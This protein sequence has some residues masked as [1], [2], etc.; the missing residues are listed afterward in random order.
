MSADGQVENDMTDQSLPARQ[1]QLTGLFPKERIAVCLLFLANGFYTG[2][3]SLKIPELSERLNL[4]PFYIALIVVFFG[5]GSITIM[6]L[7]GARIAKYGTS[8]V[9]KAT[10][11]VFLFTMIG[12]SLAPNVW[13]AAIAVFLFGGFAGAMDVAMNANAVEVEKSMR[14]A[15]MSSCHAFWS[16]GALIGSSAG[17]FMI[18]HFGALPHSLIITVVDAIFLVA[19][20]SMILHDGPHIEDHHDEAAAKASL[21]KSP[22]PWLIGIMALF[23][24]VQ[25]G[26]VIDWSALYLNRELSSSL[27][28]A[29]F[30]AGSFHGAMTI[31]RFFGDGIRDRLGAV[32]TM[33]VSGV[34]A[35]VGML[36]GGFAPNAYVAIA[37]FALSGLGI[38]NMVPI[39]FSAA[40]NLPGMAKGVGLSVVTILGYSGT[41]FAPTLFGFVAEHVGFS[42]IYIGTPMLLIVVLLISGLARYADGIKGGGH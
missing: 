20:F 36:I 18:E 7:C 23:C 21:F 9:A 2:A 42:A 40:G 28:L 4:S 31:M 11:M 41:L 3:W 35:F 24:M 1:A 12:I 14:R 19:A 34:V 6:P 13:T 32:Q 10:S 29:A 30:A 39:A 26:I 33:R 15:I 27:T 37:G 5:L 22:L 16:L 8:V 38:S 17:G 25:E